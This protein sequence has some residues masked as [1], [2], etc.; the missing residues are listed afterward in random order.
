MIQMD[1][2]RKTADQPFLRDKSTISPK[3]VSDGGNTLPR[4]YKKILSRD[5][6]QLF[7]EFFSSEKCLVYYLSIFYYLVF[8]LSFFST[9]PGVPLFQ[10]KVLHT[11]P[12]PRRGK[13]PGISPDH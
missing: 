12:N 3:T 8:L 10:E 5:T 1:A 11:L 4:I 6:K 2:S 13:P 9:P 7:G